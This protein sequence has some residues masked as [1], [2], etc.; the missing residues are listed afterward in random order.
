MFS[1]TRD[2]AISRILEYAGK[3]QKVIVVLVT[4]HTE[5]EFN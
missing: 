1:S 5:R 2:D 3:I 4:A